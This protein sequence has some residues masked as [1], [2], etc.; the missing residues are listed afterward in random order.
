MTGI[1]RRR[2]RVAAPLAGL[3]AVLAAL[4]ACAGPF[5]YYEGTGVH[6][7]TAA[8]VAGHWENVEGTRV[9]LHEGGTA[10]LEKLDEQD[11]AFE[12]GRRLSG[13]GTWQLTDEEGGQVVRLALTAR[14]RVESRSSAATTAASAPEPPSAYTWSFHVDRDRHDGLRLFF[15]Y[16]DPDLG[17]TY[18]M[19][20]ETGP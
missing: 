4:T 11:F 7:A 14:T 8:E 12:D 2:G 9:V 3:V 15:F 6:D 19:T 16:G 10:L 1:S 20:R 18:V 13:T 17:N 5:Q